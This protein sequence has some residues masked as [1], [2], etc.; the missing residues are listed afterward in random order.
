MVHH[1]LRKPRKK[2][3]MVALSMMLGQTSLPCQCNAPGCIL[4]YGLAISQSTTVDQVY[5]G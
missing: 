2:R 4:L 1:A 5:F 3:R